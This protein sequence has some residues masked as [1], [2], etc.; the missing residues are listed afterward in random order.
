M[1]PIHKMKCS[2]YTHVHRAAHTSFSMELMG[3]HKCSRKLDDCA[4]KVLRELN[5]FPVA[6]GDL[7]TCL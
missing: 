6:L 1:G 3:C 2:P 4:C 5:C 7:H